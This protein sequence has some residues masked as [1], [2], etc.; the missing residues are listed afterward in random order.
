[1]NECPI[2]EA[3][4]RDMDLY[5]K[6]YQTSRRLLRLDRYEREFLG[7][8]ETSDEILGDSAMARARM[9]QIRHFIINLKNGDEKLLLYYHYVRGESVEKCAELLGISRAS[10][11]RLK[12][13]ALAL[14]AKEKNIPKQ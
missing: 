10:G 2:T 5:L 9:F 11:F 7:Y 12:K 6:G 4:I 13:K 3:E 1:M 14:A 8:R